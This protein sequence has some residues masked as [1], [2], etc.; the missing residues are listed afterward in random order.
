M[1]TL[2]AK[3]AEILVTMDDERQEIPDGG[4]LVRDGYVEQVGPTD[5]LPA[6]ADVVLDMSG[7]IVLPGFVNTHHHLDQ[8]LD[9]GVA[10]GSGHQPLPVVAGPLPDLGAQ[11]PGSD[12]DEH[13]DR[14]C[15]A[16][17]VRVHDRVRPLVRLAERIEC[18]RPDRS[19]DRVWEPLP[20]VTRQ[21][22]ARRVTGRASPDETC[23]DEDFILED[24]SGLIETYPRHLAW[25]DASDRA[26]SVF[27]VLGHR[28]PLVRSAELA[29]AVREASASTPTCARRWTR[30]ATPS[31][32]T[33]CVRSSGWR[34]WA[35]SVTRFGIARDS[36]QCRRD[37]EVR[38]TGTGA[39]TVPA[40][41]CALPRGSLRSRTIA[42][43]G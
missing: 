26:G 27:A 7:Q 5:E 28:R 34:R 42:T 16:R 6:D 35:G 11:D 18:R 23:E 1:S 33:G 43:P 29:R 2:L 36:C 25:F 38:E 17:S 37:Q 21:H 12:P 40:R 41:T 8:T 32:P 13:A 9:E 20:R 15:R 19:S 3:N 24:S 39:L 30:S 22:V 10:A 31:R 4:I 14:P